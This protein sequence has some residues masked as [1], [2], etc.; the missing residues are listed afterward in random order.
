MWRQLLAYAILLFFA[1]VGIA[2][3]LRPDRFMKSWHRGGEMLTESNRFQIRLVG[4]VLAAGAM[5]VLYSIT[6]H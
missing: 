5:Y 6:R 2:H 3:A 4:L 1:A